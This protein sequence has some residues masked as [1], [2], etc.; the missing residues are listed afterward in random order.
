ML[1]WTGCSD[2]DPYA[3]PPE[4]PGFGTGDTSGCTG[5]R[6]LPSAHGG[7]GT[8]YHADGTGVCGFPATHQWR[9][10]AVNAVDL[11]INHCGGCIKVIGP[12]DS[13]V[14][15]VVNKC[16]ECPSGHLDF[17]RRALYTVAGDGV[18]YTRQLI[19][20]YVPCE[21]EGTIRYAF[22]ENSS[23]WWLAVQVRNH[24]HPVALFEYYDSTNG[25]WNSV[26]R[27]DWGYYVVSGGLGPGPFRFRVTD[28]EG[29]VL[30]DA[31]VPLL[32]GLEFEGARQFPQCGG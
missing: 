19:W 22:Q 12:A 30:Q 11:D 4:S 20:Y 18:G 6:G 7:I 25:S 26:P 13:L 16:P 9:I 24:I 21:L 5:Y 32:P 3:P 28:T 15:R 1:L 23:Q 27:V 14:V 2:D 17:H 29:N 8:Y 10:V 31:D